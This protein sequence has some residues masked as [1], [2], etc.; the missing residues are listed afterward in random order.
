MKYRIEHDSMGAVKIPVSKYW[1]AQTERSRSNFKIGPAASMPV[2][3]IK[4]FG[5]I[6]K[7]AAITNF[8]LGVLPSDKKEMIVDVCNEIINGKLNDQFPLVIWQT[9]SGTHTNMNLNEVITNRAHVRNGGNLTDKVRILHPNDDVNKSQSS[10]DTFPTAMHI[11]SYMVI[12]EITLPGMQKLRNSLARKSDEFKD[13]VKIGRTHYMD[14]VPLTLGQELS[15]YVQQIDN[16]IRAIR[17]SLVMVGELA[18]GGS[19]VGTGLNTPS[20]Y[21]ELVAGKIAELTGFPFVS[22]ANKFE[23]LAAH[24]AMVELSSALKRSAISLMK[25]ANDIRILSS[26]PRGGISE[27]IIPANE[28]GSSI[29]PGKVNPTQAEALLMVCAQVIGND[30]AV[31]IGNSGGNLELNTFKPLIAAN[32]LQ[33]ARLL[34]DA[35]YSF[36]ENCIKGIIPDYNTIKS[37]LDN[38]LMLVTALTPHIGYDNSARIA[39]K[40]YTENT[41]LREAAIDLGLVTGKQFDEWVIPGKMT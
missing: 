28:P 13:I 17:N 7:A 41:T 6:K 26:G 31:T 3:I 35:C 18:L 10:N 22:A 5:Y 15:G 25:I 19:A 4:A 32:V 39:K 20:G 12:E 21:S 33:S 40:A 36:S 34:G 14:A 29:M 8:D 38:S 11:A 27:I 2:E 23:S 24:D 30:V 1:G 16:G 9:G 37:H